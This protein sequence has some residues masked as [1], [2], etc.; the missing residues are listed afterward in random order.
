MGGREGGGEGGGEEG[1]QGALEEGP[2]PAYGD[3]DGDGEGR[4]VEKETFGAQ[5]VCISESE[6]TD[7]LPDKSPVDDQAWVW[8]TPTSEDVKP[9]TLL[10]PGAGDAVSEGTRAAATVAMAAAEMAGIK[11]AEHGG[12]PV[13]VPIPVGSGVLPEPDPT[14]LWEGALPGSGQGSKDESP[15]SLSEGGLRLSPAVDRQGK[16]QGHDDKGGGILDRR[17]GDDGGLGLGLGL[18]LGPLVPP[19]GARRGRPRWYRRTDSEVP[20]LWAWELSKRVSNPVVYELL[21]SHGLPRHSRRGIWMVWAE[22]RGIAPEAAQEGNEEGLGPVANIIDHDVQ[23]TKLSHHLFDANRGGG[24]LRGP[25]GD[26]KAGMPMLK[27]IL[28][29]CASSR[30]VK[31]AGYI[32]G[33]NFLAGFMLTVFVD[34]AVA[35][36]RAQR[37]MDQ[38]QEQWAAEEVQQDWKDKCQGQ[39]LGEGGGGGKG[40]W[41]DETLLRCSSGAPERLVVDAAEVVDDRED[42]EKVLTDSEELEEEVVQTML[43]LI[44]LQ[45]GVVALDLKGL[46]MNT[47][48]VHD[49]LA[50]YVN[51]LNHHLMS[52]NLELTVLTPRWFI[53]MYAASIPSQAVVSHIWDLYFYHGRRG[54]AVLVWVALCLLNGCKRQ[55]LE[56]DSLPAALGCIRRYMEGLETFF[57]IS[58]A[59][60][61]DLSKVVSAWEEQ[62]N[63]RQIAARDGKGPLSDAT[64]TRLVH[65]M[66]GRTP[67][68]R[69]SPMSQRAFDPSDNAM[70]PV[71]LCTTPATPPRSPFLWAV[72]RL[73]NSNSNNSG[74]NNDSN[75]S[76]NGPM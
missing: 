76:N 69:A 73:L 28:L 25:A 32:Q 19:T 24:L 75:G 31:D 43:R 48:L 8:E 45:G 12:V 68:G 13:P 44:E 46:H 65:A 47:K 51:T 41:G 49:L 26:L 70:T 54:P 29:Q 53:C 21:L 72:N 61:V 23:R 33:M 62:G 34:N 6:S 59:S 58:A 27:R 50:K 74:G 16:G 18:G 2:S 10:A 42:L 22:A 55:L 56:C 67:E 52:V 11:A 63:N 3:G 37:K 71:R 4:G 66:L 1:D 36:L 5:G 64:V 15:E 17:V 57:D 38:R 7:K 39:V 40:Q 9:A 30:E 60:P 20:D 35:M 14:P